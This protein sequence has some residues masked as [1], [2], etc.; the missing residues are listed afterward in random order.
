MKICPVC[1]TSY[2]DAQNFCLNDGTPLVISAENEPQQ[3][4]PLE[5]PTVVQAKASETV[6]NVSPTTQPN[7]SAAQ[8]N[9]GQAAP[10][11]FPQTPIVVEKKSNTGKIVFLTALVTLL[12]VALTGGAIYLATRNRATQI[13][14]NNDNQNASKPKNA[15]TSNANAAVVKNANAA[16]MNSNANVASSPSLVL[17]AEQT[18]KIRKDVN[19]SLD[20]WKD[21]TEDGDI[22]KHMSF[23][24]DTVDFYNASGASSSIIR[25]DRQKAFDTYPDIEIKLSNIKITPDS[26]GEKATVVLDKTWRFE[27]DE[28]VS[29]GSV[30]QQLTLSKIN[31]RWLITGEKDLKVY[32]KY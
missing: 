32:Y 8:S 14:Q 4:E 12:V 30:Q 29:E 21:S 1:Q 19:Q 17:S 6:S 9:L 13:A 28:K 16:N 11:V 25:A 18:T 23:Y 10:P 27:N 20:G 2:D 24:A 7:F 15:N 5:P 31:G 22:N 3:V 26:T